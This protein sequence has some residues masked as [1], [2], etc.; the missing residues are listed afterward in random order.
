[1]IYQN[2]YGF[3]FNLSASGSIGVVP[4]RASL[5]YYDQDGVLKTNNFKRLTGALNLNPKLLDN[6]L[7]INVALK[8]SET[9]NRWAN[10]G[11]IGN[12]VTVDP[13]KP[14]D[15]PIYKVGGYREWLQTGSNNVPIEVASRTPG[16]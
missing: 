15:D 8:L 16:G 12:A 2:A 6:H 10:E 1:V 4:F 13:T 3:D 7:S 5:G 9:K 14:V 11:A